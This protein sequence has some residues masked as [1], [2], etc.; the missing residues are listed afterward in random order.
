MLCIKFP[1]GLDWLCYGCA[2]SRFNQDLR[3]EGAS[4]YIHTL[5]RKHT[6]RLVVPGAGVER[7]SQGDAEWAIIVARW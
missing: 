5:S 7:T 6:P 2:A 1:T 4:A 3:P